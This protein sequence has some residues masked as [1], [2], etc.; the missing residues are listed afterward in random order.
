MTGWARNDAAV[1]EVPCVLPTSDRF[2]ILPLRFCPGH[3]EPTYTCLIVASLGG[4]EAANIPYNFLSSDGRHPCEIAF[5]L[6]FRI[7]PLAVNCG[8]DSLLN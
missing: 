3:F 1:A 5:F 8:Y 6:L 2:L 7:M 4:P